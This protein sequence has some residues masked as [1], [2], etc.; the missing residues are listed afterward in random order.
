M[1]AVILFIVLLEKKP[2]HADYSAF[3]E[4]TESS[5]KAAKFKVGGRVSITK[6]KN[7]FSKGYTEKWS[8]EIL[9]INFVSKTNPWTDKIQNLNGEKVIGSF[10]EKELLLSKL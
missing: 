2:I 5:H 10:Y 8:K 1:N 3:T 7:S 9:V 6:Y 4:E